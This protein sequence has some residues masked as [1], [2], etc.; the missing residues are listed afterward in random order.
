MVLYPT[1]EAALAANPDAARAE[2]LRQERREE[3]SHREMRERNG[4]IARA[5]AVGDGRLPAKNGSAV[6]VVSGPPKLSE[7]G[8]G[9]SLSGLLSAAP[10]GWLVRQQGVA[11]YAVRQLANKMAREAIEKHERGETTEKELLVELV[12]LDMTTGYKPGGRVLGLK[13]LTDMWA[14][15]L[16]PESREK[17]LEYARRLGLAPKKAS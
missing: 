11:G 12:A 7:L 9:V 8:P 1:R 17:Q 15:K 5:R 14:A 10:P 4:A 16:A 6:A 2:R 3:A 13:I